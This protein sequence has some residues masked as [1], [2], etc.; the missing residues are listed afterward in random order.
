MIHC[1]NYLTQNVYS[2]EKKNLHQIYWFFENDKSWMFTWYLSKHIYGWLID[3]WSWS[4]YVVPGSFLTGSLLV[5]LLAMI[6][7][8]F[9]PSLWYFYCEASQ[10]RAE[11]MG[12]NKWF[13]PLNC[14]YHV[15]GHNKKLVSTRSRLRL[16]IISDYVFQH[17]LELIYRRNL[18]K[19]TE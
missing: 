7:T 17:T 19:F 14:V 9:H 6:W 11:T 3:W 5:P 8:I 16:E 4:L 2:V 18:E 1:K 12:Q 15:F 10:P 13:S